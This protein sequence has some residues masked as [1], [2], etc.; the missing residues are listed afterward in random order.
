MG[1]SGW[2]VKINKSPLPG[3]ARHNTSDMSEQEPQTHRLLNFQESLF[4]A[5]ALNSRAYFKIYFSLFQNFWCSITSKVLAAFI[6][7]CNFIFSKYLG[8]FYLI[9]SQSSQSPKRVTVKCS[10]FSSNSRLEI[11]YIHG[12]L[13]YKS[14]NR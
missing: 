11:V 14:Q 13:Q 7:Y 1:Y 10:I 9:S 12:N 6:L 2:S 8:H 5:Y 3:K 4:P